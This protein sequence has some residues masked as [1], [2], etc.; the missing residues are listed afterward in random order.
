MV[1]PL[2]LWAACSNASPPFQQLNVHLVVRGLKLNTVFKVQPHQCR[3][4]GHNHFPTPAGHAIPDT[5]QDAIGLLGHLGT[6]LAHI[7]AA[8]NQ[9]QQVLFSRAAFQPLFPKPVALHGV[10]VT[11]VQ[12]LTLGLVEPHTIGLSPSVQPVQIPLAFLPSSR[13]TL[14]HNLVSSANLL[15]ARSIP[16]SRSLIKILNKTGPKTEPWGTPLVT[17]RQLDLVPFTTTLW[18]QPSSQFFTQQI[19]HPS[20]P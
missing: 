14:P 15:R 19:V 18:A 5:S 7:Q 13:S 8:V 10:V 9:Y 6:L 16:S 4:Q 11:Q 20:K 1:T 12:D 3:A 17:G 2:P